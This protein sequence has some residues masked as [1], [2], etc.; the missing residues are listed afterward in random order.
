[1]KKYCP[2]CGTAN[3]YTL[4]EPK[5]CIKCKKSMAFNFEAPIAR[6][7]NKIVP[8]RTIK[9]K[10]FLEN[11][12]EEEYSDASELQE[13]NLS[14]KSVAIDSN[15]PTN[16]F[17][18]SELMSQKPNGLKREVG[19]SNNNPLNEIQRVMRIDQVDLSE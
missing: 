8:Q 14:Y 4:Q 1:M 2:E 11:E 5:N 6:A 15:N 3:E 16:S 9:R 7:E 10:S 12:G 18:M 17:S 13:Y 19:K